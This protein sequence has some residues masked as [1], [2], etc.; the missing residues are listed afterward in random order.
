METKNQKSPAIQILEA[1]W[2]ATPYPSHQHVNRTMQSALSLVISSGI[3]FHIDDFEYIHKTFR[4]G[5]WM[6]R[7]S[8]GHH[9]G[10]HYYAEACNSNPS[11]VAAWEHYYK[12][13]GFILDGKRMYC[14]SR[15]LY[16]GL[17]CTITGWSEDNQRLTAV[18]YSGSFDKGKRTLLSFDKNTWLAER[19]TIKLV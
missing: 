2:I 13:Q 9:L 19:K 11:C 6:G 12:R 14:N 18:G 15:F 17:G 1:I 8:N 16:D 4:P 5:Y 10:E 7:S 3:N